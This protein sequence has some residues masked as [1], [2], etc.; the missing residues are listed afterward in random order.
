MLLSTS[1]IAV[2]RLW[3]KQKPSG[4]FRDNRWQHEAL[5]LLKPIGLLVDHAA[6]VGIGREV[7]AGAT[8]ARSVRVGLS[9]ERILWTA[10]RALPPVNFPAVLGSSTILA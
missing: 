8:A 5:L 6:D 1:G 7:H 9:G 4:E 3:S 10:R 2:V